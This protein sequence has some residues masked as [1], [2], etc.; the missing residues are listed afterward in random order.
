M[1]ENNKIEMAANNIVA[2][3]P[4]DKEALEERKYHEPT[5][6]ASRLLPVRLPQA[7]KVQ[8]EFSQAA[9]VCYKYSETRCS[10][11]Y[12]FPLI[13]RTASTA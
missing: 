5:A 7:D 3:V 8:T 2:D 1:N 4:C 13:I 9:P 10:H 6:A 12:L 11:G